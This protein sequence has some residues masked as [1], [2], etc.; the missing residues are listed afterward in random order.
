MKIF[1]AWNIDY[2]LDIEH[3]HKIRYSIHL[4]PSKIPLILP[5]SD[6]AKEIAH[7]YSDAYPVASIYA[8]PKL[9]KI[10]FSLR[11]LLDEDELAQ[12]A[13]D[14]RRDEHVKCIKEAF[15]VIKDLVMYK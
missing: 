6:V 4:H 8:I 7:L 11:C 14:V 9:N 13:K 15:K 12:L 2:R 3:H 5:D 1:F 10:Q